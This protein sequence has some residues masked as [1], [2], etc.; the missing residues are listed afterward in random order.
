MNTAV[1]DQSA[2]RKSL[3]VSLDASEV[4]AQHATTVAEFSRLAQIPGFRP[5][6]A[7]A[8]V[9]TKRFEKDIADEFKQKVVTAAYRE[10]VEKSKLDVLNL[11]RA[12]PGPIENGKPVEVTFAVDVRPEFSIPDYAELTTEVASTE[13]TDAEIDQVIESLRSERA[14]FKAA[15]RPAQKGDY[16]KLSYEGSVEGQPILELVPDKQ[17]YGK[18]PQTWEEVES[19]QEGLIPGLGQQLAGLKAGDK[20]DVTLTFPADFSGAPALAG[21]TAVYS[22]E[23]LEVRERVLPPLD[24]DFFKAQQVDDLEQLKSGIRRNLEM[25][26]EYQ[27]KS[28]QRRQVVET[29]LQKTD[30]E[31]PASLV[32]LETQ[33]VLRRFIE[34][35]M[36]RGV[37][38]EQ[39]EKDKKELYEGARKSAE[40]RVKSQLIL[41]Q[42][43]E[44]EGL[45]VS[46]DDIN[47]FILQ[48]SQRSRVAPDKLVK[49]IAK[50]RE[51]LRSIQQDI[52]FDKAVEFLVSKANV[53]TKA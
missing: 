31:A 2:T 53:V 32:E 6:K 50:D 40:S 18:V 44:K 4:S 23:L 26:K 20:K 8:S 16:V 45:K 9:I 27:N 14:D 21:K 30:F 38:Q 15:D 1:Q 42:I 10:G 52:I 17:I 33:N 5:G 34:E 48:E 3:V 35:N 47:Q 12:T 22:V 29:M 13:V 24:E 28:S 46:E 36:R 7:P 11:V 25:Q 51:Q 37:S 49:Q 43:A 41:S 39:F 19:A